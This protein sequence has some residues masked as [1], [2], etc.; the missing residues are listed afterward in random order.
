[1][2]MTGVLA[3]TD[4]QIIVYIN[5]DDQ[6]NLLGKTETVKDNLNPKF[7][8][9]ILVDYRFERS[10]PLR[11]EIVHIHGNKPVVIGET[12]IYL[13][14]IVSITKYSQA[15][16]AVKSGK[17][18]N[19]HVAAEQV[20]VGGEAKHV[21][22]ICSARGLKNTCLIGKSDPFFEIFRKQNADWVL[23]HR[24][25]F[26]LSNLDPIWKP[27]YIPLLKLNNGDYSRPLKIKVYS[28]SKS[29][30]EVIG[31]FETSLEAIVNKKAATRIPIINMK[32]KEK[33]KKKDKIVDSGIFS[34]DLV[35]VNRSYSFVDYIQA[36]FEIQLIVA[37]DYTGSNGPVH[38]HS[39]LHYLKPGRDNEYQKAIRAV[40]GILSHYD[41]DG[42]IPL[43]GFGAKFRDGTVSHCFPVNGNVSNPEVKGIDGVMKAYAD[44]LTT[45]ELWGPT[46]FADVIT[47]AA[48]E[49]AIYHESESGECAFVILL[50]LTDGEITD[51]SDTVKAIV[52]AS[53]YPFAIV[54]VGVG[55]AD[56]G[57]MDI[58]DGDDERLKTSSNKVA[59]R[60]IVQFVALREY[61]KDTN[62]N[63]LQA[64]TLNEIPDLFVDYMAS[65][66]IAP[67]DRALAASTP[68]SK[69][70]RSQRQ[71]EARTQH[72]LACSVKQQA[73][74]PPRPGTGPTVNPDLM[75]RQVT[76]LPGP[77]GPGAAMGF[78]MPVQQQQVVQQQVVQQVQ[79]QVVQQP[80]VAAVPY[81]SF[82]NNVPAGGFQPVAHTASNPGYTQSNPNP[83]YQQPVTHTAPNPGYTQS[84]PGAGAYT[85]PYMQ[86]GGGAPPAF[87]G[88]PQPAPM[89]QPVGLGFARAL[90][91]YSA[92][93]ASQLSFQP[94]TVITILVKDPSGW[95]EGD[96]NGQRGWFPSNFVELLQ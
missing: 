60:D 84:N 21:R 50:I 45:V 64:D 71:Q 38:H 28:H 29:K 33:A 67:K 9:N 39:S 94:G 36:G 7:A 70:A 91:V 20:N 68:D 12:V 24:T 82:D 15:V 78:A 62:L 95:W 72:A 83:G 27:F 85:P 96:I 1:M 31:E 66:G 10:Q 11:F 6:W 30:P 55:T 48:G 74:P 69:L 43:Y 86:S 14:D 34:F 63:R 42:D 54:I 73:A 17:T 23:V 51:M 47:A 4:C 35:Q 46:N 59:Y 32:K 5:E 40:G 16:K 77:P 58:L 90:Y 75:P 18:F 81:P 76:T 25:E 92:V 26:V 13:S 79:Q 93:S 41:S 3:K 57:K 56:F 19:L 53:A 49:A 52:K 22:F 89:P 37:I 88:L 61:A 87:G 44:S 80:A 65:N 2:D 8:T